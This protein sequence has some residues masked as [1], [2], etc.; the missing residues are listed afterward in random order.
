MESSEL[1][2]WTNEVILQLIPESGSDINND[3]T[4]DEDGL[5]ADSLAI[6]EIMYSVTDKFGIEIADENI[7]EIRT[8]GDLKLYI[9]THSD[10]FDATDAEKLDLD[11]SRFKE[12]AQL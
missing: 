1:D 10:K 2:K 11:K 7:E 8:V 6:V 3:E 12:I 4:F 5:D 9:I